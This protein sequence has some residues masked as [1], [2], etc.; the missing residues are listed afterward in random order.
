MTRYTS[1]QRRPTSPSER[2]EGLQS[3]IHPHPK[4]KSKSKR[5]I[6]ILP[7][8]RHF[9]LALTV[10]LICSWQ[11]VAL[12]IPD[13]PAQFSGVGPSNDDNW[14]LKFTTFFCIE[15]RQLQPLC[16]KT[17]ACKRTGTAHAQHCAHRFCKGLSGEYGGGERWLCLR[18]R[19][20]YLRCLWQRTAA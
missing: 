6:S 17:G 20:L 3:N 5:D 11:R 15:I 19:R 12:G 7:E 4:P 8:P 2:Q 18:P 16:G 13:K 1:L 9:Y 14:R 10:C